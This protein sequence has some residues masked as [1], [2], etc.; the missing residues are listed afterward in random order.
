MDRREMARILGR[1]GGRKRAQRL[2]GAQKKQIASLGGTA[3][4]RSLEAARRIRV[5]LRYAAM[6]VVLRGPAPPVVRMK[7]F[8][9]RLPGIYGKP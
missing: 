7:R 1:R 5:N 9:G 3:R 4:V 8:S 6:V 2:S